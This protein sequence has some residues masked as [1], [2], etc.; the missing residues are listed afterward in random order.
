MG[1]NLDRTRTCTLER[2]LL[3]ADEEASDTRPA[4]MT[5]MPGSSTADQTP[6]L[7]DHGVGMNTVRTEIATLGGRTLL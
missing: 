1:L 3:I 4:G 6:E 5:F 7:V 2:Q